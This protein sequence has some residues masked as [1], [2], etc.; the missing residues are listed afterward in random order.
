M[1]PPASRRFGA[2][3]VRLILVWVCV[4]LVASSHDHGDTIHVRS[5]QLIQ[6]AI[7]G[8][9]RGDRILVEAGT[10]AEQLTIAN[11]GIALVGLGAILVRPKGSI[12]NTCSGLA[13]KDTE[14][15]ICVTGSD[16]KLADFVGE[17]RK[18]LSV[19]R[20]VE[21]VSITGFQVH[22]FSGENIAVVGAQDTRVTG[23]RLMDGPTYGFLTDGS[24]NTQVTGNTI[25]SATLGFIGLCM[26]DV[27]GV[28][29]SNNHISGYNI[30]LCVQT[31][32]A[33]VRNNDVSDCC[34][35]AFVDP[36]IDGAKLRHNH[37]G[38]TNPSCKTQPGFFGAYGIIIDGAVNT[39]IRHNR[40]TNQT[41]SGVADIFSAGLA[42]FDEPAVTPVAIASGNVVKQNTLLNNDLDLLV[43]T[44]GTSNVI[45]RNKCSSSS[46]DGLCAS[47]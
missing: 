25:V 20:P 34:I 47:K 31:S 35:G 17:H 19:G 44:S 3:R 12:Q 14:A 39:D 40:I 30:G 32:G 11:D 21:D 6:A 7:D 37:I 41:D 5:G 4:T 26:D 1:T 33:D 8:A 15:G 13:G 23:N 16:V 38:A 46:P 24:N 43:F 29:V 27:A 42:I 2:S 18:V 45:T 10:Y 36:G 28:H 22:G 9:H